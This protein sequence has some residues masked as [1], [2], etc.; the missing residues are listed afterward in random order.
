MASK[1]IG[2]KRGEEEV[3]GSGK[4]KKLSNKP[5]GIIRGKDEVKMR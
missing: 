5:M 2:I 3:N 4:P 1:P